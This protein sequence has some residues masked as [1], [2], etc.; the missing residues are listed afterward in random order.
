MS[1]VREVAQGQYVGTY[2]EGEH[3]PLLNRLVKAIKRVVVAV[4]VQVEQAINEVLQSNKSSNGWKPLETLIK[5][6]FAKILAC[7]AA[8]MWSSEYSPEG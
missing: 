8:M 4:V 6:T 1:P 7:F 2:L 5:H 3:Q